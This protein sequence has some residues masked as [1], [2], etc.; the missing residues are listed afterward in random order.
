MGALG[1]AA[2]LFGRDDT[3]RSFRTARDTSRA[4]ERIRSQSSA[5]P[6]QADP[7]QPVDGDHFTVV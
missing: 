7:T 6:G 1:L 2:S 3:W 4:S 5:E